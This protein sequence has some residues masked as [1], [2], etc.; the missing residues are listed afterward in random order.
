[1]FSGSAAALLAGC[2]FT[3]LLGWACVT[4][5]RTRR[6]PNALV[7]TLAVGG[8]VFSAVASDWPGAL[9]RSVGGVAVG[10][11][12][13]LPFWLMRLLGAGDVKLFAG[14]AAWLGPIG[15]VEGALAA[16]LVGG[17]L[18][19][20]WLLRDFGLRRTGEVIALLA[21]LPR[22]PRAMHGAVLTGS[23]LRLPYGIALAVGGAVA[24][25]WPGLFL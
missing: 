25:W 10:L 20:I 24:G 7:T 1:M 23:R 15:A 9:G 4:D 3:L 17:A 6:I 12:I 16:A 21:A 18:S 13:W 2:V 11:A 5:A 19:L 22:T 14:A 8:I